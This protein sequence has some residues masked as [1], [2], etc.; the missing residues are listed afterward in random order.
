MTAKCGSCEGGGSGGCAGGGVAEP[1][2]L[3]FGCPI[4]GR[5]KDYPVEEM[6]EGAHL[7]CPFCGLK[8]TLHGHMLQEVQ[9]RIRKIEAGDK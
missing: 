6:I 8:L 5:K 1:R 9:E 4:C 3:D 2:K 7:E